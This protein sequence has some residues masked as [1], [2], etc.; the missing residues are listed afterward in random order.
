MPYDQ[1]YNASGPQI[2]GG[3]ATASGRAAVA[4]AFAPPPGTTWARVSTRLTWYRR[5]QLLVAAVLVMVIGVFLAARILG[6]P[7]GI[8]VFVVV[9]VAAVVVWLLVEFNCRSWGYLEQP[10]EFLMAHGVLVR[11]FLMVP[12]GRIQLVDVNSNVLQQWFGIATVRLYTAAATT[13]ARLPGIPRQEAER[14]RD[15]LV[16]KSEARSMGL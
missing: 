9:L 14:L 6:L 5:V 16:A 3:H 12:Y 10:D 11:R 13:D 2:A 8:I 7:G 15:R 1:P 4:G